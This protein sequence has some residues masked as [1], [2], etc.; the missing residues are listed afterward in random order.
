M[1]KWDRCISDLISF[2]ILIAHHDQGTA[3]SELYEEWISF[4]QASSIRFRPPHCSAWTK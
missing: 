3:Y 2:A 1:V 4:S